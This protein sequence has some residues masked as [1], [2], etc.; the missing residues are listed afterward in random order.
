LTETEA[1]AQGRKVTV[2]KFPWGASGRALTFDRTD[3]LT[4]LIIDPETER[5][6]GVGIVGHG[7][8]ELIGE[9]VLAVEMG[10][11]ARDL[12]ETVHPHPTLSETVMESAEL[13]FGHATHAYVRK[14]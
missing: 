13:F 3:G 9:G 5:I 4:K 8:G 1:K 10:A 2:A 14:R 12:A 6:L 7:A 11:T